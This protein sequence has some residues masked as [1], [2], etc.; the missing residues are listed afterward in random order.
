MGVLS[1]RSFDVEGHVTRAGKPAGED[2]PPPASATAAV[3][4]TLVAGGAAGVA[5][6]STPPLNHGC[7]IYSQMEYFVDVGHMLV[8][9]N[10][11]S[12]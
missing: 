6:S 7:N 3:V 12:D 9:G 8:C 1:A 5:K 11:C 2:D 10:T 4:L